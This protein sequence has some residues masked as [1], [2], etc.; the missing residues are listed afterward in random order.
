MSVVS[1]A[2]VLSGAIPCVLSM[3]V[4]ATGPARAIDA[5]L[6][7]ATSLEA[8]VRD[9]L[10]TLMGPSIKIGDRPVQLTAAGDHYD[11]VVPM[12][13]AGQ[14][15]SSG[16]PLAQDIRM[17]GTARPGEN[18]TWIIEGVKLSN[19]LVFT[20]DIP[21]PA[22][23]DAPG[24]APTGPGGAKKADKPATKTV[25]VTYTMDQQGQVGRI[26][27]D[28]S[29]KTP[30]TWTTTIQ[31]TTVK[32]EGGPAAT[33]TVTGPINAVSTLRPAGSDRVDALT[34]GTIQDYRISSAGGPLGLDVAMKTVR[35][36]SAL[37]GVSRARGV[38]LIQAMTTAISTAMTAGKPGQPPEVAPEMIKAILAALQDFASDYSL[39]ETIDGLIA[40]SSGQAAALDQLRLGLDAKSDAGML[41]AGMTLG[42]TGLTLP[43]LDLGDM[44]ALLPRRVLMRPVIGGVAVVDVMR[45]A[46]LAS[47][48]KDPGPDDFAALFSHGGITGG[49]ES[50]VIELAGATITGQGKV[51]ATGPSPDAITGSATLTAENFD[52]AMQKVTAIPALAQQAVPV[53]VFIKGIGRTVDNKLVWDVVYKDN[54]LLIN[55]VD[56]TAMAGGGAA[57]AP[58]AAARPTAPAA[59]SVQA[60]SVPAPS[61]GGTAKAPQRQ[62]QVPS[63][64]R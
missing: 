48:N 5:T 36:A 22:G 34:E 63:W 60:P 19:P 12:F 42:M 57:P 7:E 18:G 53:M 52:V 44:A 2:L 1:R 35:I 30:S 64:A 28:P 46:T 8:A 62:G 26:L 20:L 39:D 15:T 29:F 51:V 54:K 38:A 10:A 43:G 27:W 23:D 17:T 31:S 11:V 24:G 14:K 32:S 56:L 47:D 41:R 3:L 16:V 40:K 9:S 59:P 4:A 49:L 55:N 13:R 50:M 37:N 61:V 25:P 58:R 45:F 33:S 21:V 6:A